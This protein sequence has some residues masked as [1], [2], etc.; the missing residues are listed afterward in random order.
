MKYP[1][2][3]RSQLQLWYG[4]LLAAMLLGFAV[5]AFVFERE[6]RLRGVDEI[7]RARIAEITA[8]FQSSPERGKDIRVALEER[9]V[10]AFQDKF[11]S[12]SGCYFCLLY[13]SPSPRD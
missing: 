7:L 5:F 6:R 3:L 11:S 4:I 13:T 1:A 12:E 9:I 2:S 10:P 8:A